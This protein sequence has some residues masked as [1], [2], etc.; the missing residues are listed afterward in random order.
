MVRSAIDCPYF[1]EFEVLYVVP[2]INS[3]PGHRYHRYYTLRYRRGVLVEG[4]KLGR[5]VPRPLMTKNA[6]AY[7]TQQHYGQYTAFD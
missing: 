2:G 3:R 6:I 5:A 7:L 4:K 1:K